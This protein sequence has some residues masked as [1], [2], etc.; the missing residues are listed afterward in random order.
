M[1][2]FFFVEMAIAASLAGV[3]AFECKLCFRMIKNHHVPAR[4]VVAGFAT[5]RR[6]ILCTDIRLVNIFVAIG[7]GTSYLPEIPFFLF[8]M[9]GKT[10]CGQVGSF[11]GENAQ[12]VLFN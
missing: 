3:R 7:T 10:R 1:P 11:Q 12:V 9:T 6:I 8:F 4:G 5:G 2:G